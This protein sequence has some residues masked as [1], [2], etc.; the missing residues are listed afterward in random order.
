MEVTKR[1]LENILTKIVSLHRKDWENILSKV[2]WVYKITLKTIIRF[3]PFELVYGKKVILPIDLEKT[4]RIIVDVG[5][6][7]SEV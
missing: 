7:L 1:E 6:D 4:L 5:I 2:M 3:T